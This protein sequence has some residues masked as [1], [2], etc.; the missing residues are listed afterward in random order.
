[1]RTSSSEGKSGKK[2]QDVDLIVSPS[3]AQIRL[4]VPPAVL[5]P[6]TEMMQEGFFA[7]IFLLVGICKRLIDC[8]LKSNLYSIPNNNFHHYLLW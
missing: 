4:L 5:L 6:H 7:Q 3:M 1:M 2:A 8:M